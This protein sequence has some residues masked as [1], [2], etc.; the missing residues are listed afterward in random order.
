MGNTPTQQPFEGDSSDADESS[1]GASLRD[2]VASAIHSFVAGMCRRLA[3]FTEVDSRESSRV[4]DSFVPA[5]GESSQHAEPRPTPLPETD[6]PVVAA[7][8]QSHTRPVDAVGFE[9][10]PPVEAT[11][12]DGQLLLYAPDAEDPTIRS[13]TWEYVRR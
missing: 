4:E 8:E 3:L 11:Q 6:T 9:T 13:D 10:A 12:E 2:R 5:A 7:G 1:A